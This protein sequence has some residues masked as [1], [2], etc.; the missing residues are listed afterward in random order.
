MKEGVKGFFR[1]LWKGLRGVVF[2]PPT[3]IIDGV[4]KFTEGIANNLVAEPGSSTSKSRPPR[5]F[6]GRQRIYKAY[7]LEE[8]AIFNEICKIKPKKYRNFTLMDCVFWKEVN[9]DP[10][11]TSEGQKKKDDY[12]CFVIMLEEL[13][14]FNTVTKKIIWRVKTVNYISHEQSQKV[15]TIKEQHR[16]SVR[17]NFLIIYRKSFQR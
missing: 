12:F 14:L 5:V 16:K 6:Y 10:K 2:K 17:Q 3:G 4:S 13:I 8:A 1:G 9:K 11:K 7:N 15:I